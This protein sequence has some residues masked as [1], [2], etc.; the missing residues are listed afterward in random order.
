MD[1][2]FSVILC[3]HISLY[4]LCCYLLM[5]EKGNGD[6]LQHSS[7]ENSMDKP[8][9]LQSMGSQRVRPNWATSTFTFNDGRTFKI[10]P[11]SSVTLEAS[12][13]FCTLFF[14]L[15]LIFFLWY[16]KNRGFPGVLVIK[17]PPANARDTSLIPG[18]GRSPG[19]GNGNPPQ[20]SCLEFYG[21]RSLA[22]Y[23]PYGHRESDTASEQLQKCQ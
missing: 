17:N 13:L 21:Q 9:R 6:P 14:K 10:W 11:S 1:F 2:S 15:Y 3:P 18:L 8:G 5:L 23:S 7:L 20:D 4:F 19:E 16:Y 12:L 22:G